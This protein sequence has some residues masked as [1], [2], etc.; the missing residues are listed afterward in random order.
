M[1]H[2]RILV[3]L[4]RL[5]SFDTAHFFFP[6]SILSRRVDDTRQACIHTADMRLRY[7]RFCGITSRPMWHVQLLAVLFLALMLVGRM[8]IDAGDYIEGSGIDEGRKYEAQSW[9][10]LCNRWQWTRAVDSVFIFFFLRLLVK[11][12]CLRVDAWTCYSA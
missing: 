2:C 11:C 4:W 5:F 7:R 12:V 6:Q 3:H 8:H 10:Q 9:M 1:Q